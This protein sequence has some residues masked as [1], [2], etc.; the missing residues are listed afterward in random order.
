M[1]I[2]AID[3]IIIEVSPF[4]HYVSYDGACNDHLFFLDTLLMLLYI[5]VPPPFPPSNFLNTLFFGSSYELPIVQTTTLLSS[6]TFVYSIPHNSKS[7]QCA[8]TYVEALYNDDTYQ[9]T[10]GCIDMVFPK[11]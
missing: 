11:A 7:S 3:I 9:E 2:M 4:W 1:T 10:F 5:S 8:N 6:F